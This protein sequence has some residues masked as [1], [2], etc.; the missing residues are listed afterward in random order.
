MALKRIITAAVHAALAENVRSE[1]KQVGEEFHLDVEGEDFSHVVQKKGIAEQHRR[2]AEQ[3]VEDLQAQL[4]EIRRGNLP[5]ADV[6]ALENSH[7]ERYKTLETNM[8]AREAALTAEI[9]R[10]MVNARADAISKDISTAPALLSPVI[11]ARMQVI[12]KDGKF[13]LQVKDKAGVAGVMSLDDLVTEIKGDTA[14]ESVIIGSKANGGG[15]GGGGGEGGKGGGGV[16]D[17]KFN[18]LTD[19]ER[20]A[21]YQRDRAGFLKAAAEARASA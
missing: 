7:R 6:E 11:A 10:V 14:Y 16:K 19:E 21:W 8:K 18:D 3:K 1:Y 9:T 17:K 5:K 20:T 12:E 4:D 13:E 2:A 15:A